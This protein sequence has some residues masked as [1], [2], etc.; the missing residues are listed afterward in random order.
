MMQIFHVFYCCHRTGQAIDSFDPQPMRL[1]Q[2]VGI[3]TD[4]L[5]CT[6]DF[7]GLIDREDRLLQFIHLARSDDDERPIRME[8]SDHFRHACHERHLSAVE[9]QDILQ[10][11][12]KRLSVDMIS[13]RRF[14]SISRAFREARQCSNRGFF[15]HLEVRGACSPAGSY[16]TR[17]S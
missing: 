10:H 3:A 11:L 8:F 12:P 9:L 14:E 2:I 4:V 6:G 17:L 13:R 15:D 16:L 5:E 1:A 7:L